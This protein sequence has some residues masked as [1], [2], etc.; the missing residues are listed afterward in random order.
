[1]FGHDEQTNPRDIREEFQLREL[2]F[3]VLVSAIELITEF[4]KGLDR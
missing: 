4:N 3:N 2:N 1:M